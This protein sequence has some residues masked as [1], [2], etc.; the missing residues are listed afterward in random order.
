MVLDEMTIHD[1]GKE[2][3]ISVIRPD[4]TIKSA[5][6]NPPVDLE[7]FRNTAIATGLDVLLKG[8]PDN[9]LEMLTISVERTK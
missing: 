4:G 9:E 1:T 2:Y 3:V 8:V 7:T 5:N 6:A